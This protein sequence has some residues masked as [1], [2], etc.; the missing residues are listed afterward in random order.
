MWASQRLQL[1][2]EFRHRSPIQEPLG[3]SSV[4]RISL[5]SRCLNRAQQLEL[6]GRA[7]GKRVA[8]YGFRYAFGAA[9]H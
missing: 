1:S 8:I 4:G 9:I 5:G 2:T 6:K 7:I 3:E